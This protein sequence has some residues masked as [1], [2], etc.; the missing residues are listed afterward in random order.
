MVSNVKVLFIS[1]ILLLIGLCAFSLATHSYAGN[2]GLIKKTGPCAGRQWSSPKEELDCRFP[3]PP[4]DRWRAVYTKEFADA[5][6]LPPENISTDLSPGV[7]YM[8]MDVQ[9]FGVAGGIACMVNMLVKKPHDIALY[10]DGS[11]LMPF[12]EKRKL[13]HLIDLDQYKSKLKPLISF[14]AASRDYKIETSGFRSSTFA[15]YAEDVLPGYDYIAA[16]AK[17]RN[18]SMSPQYFPDGYAFWVSKA[19][20]WGKYKNLYQRLEDPGRPRSDK[21]FYNSH[22]FINIPHELVSTIFKDVPVGGR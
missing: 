7:D 19:S 1:A 16:N 2:N 5:H 4:I 6:N 3:H 15:M 11:H 17:C 20:V 13:T 14:N 21:D 8:E 12:P 18:I 10:G 9:P 22:L